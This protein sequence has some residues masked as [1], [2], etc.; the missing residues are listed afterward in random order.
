MLAQLAFAIPI[1]AG[2]SSSSMDKQKSFIKAI[3]KA[4]DISGSHGNRL[5]LISYAHGAYVNIRFE[6]Q[7]NHA[8]YENALD[9]VQFEAGLSQLESAMQI[10]VAM[11]NKT[12]GIKFGISKILILVGDGGVIGKVFSS[13]KE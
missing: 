5:G 11:F 8:Q 13:L 1:T 6:D 10:S 12:A 9:M 4:F 2:N 3:A 7:F